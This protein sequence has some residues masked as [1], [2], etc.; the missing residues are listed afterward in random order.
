LWHIPSGCVLDSPRK[1][2]CHASWIHGQAAPDTRALLARKNK[3]NES[4]PVVL[5]E[6][7]PAFGVG[8]SAFGTRRFLNAFP[9]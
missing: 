6:S 9:R 8:R 7:V 2:I 3:S 5:R 4:E 1:R